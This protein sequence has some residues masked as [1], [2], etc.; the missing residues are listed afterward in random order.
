MQK[1]ITLF[2]F[3]DES[4]SPAWWAYRSNTVGIYTYHGEY[5]ALLSSLKKLNALKAL[6]PWLQPILA[7]DVFFRLQPLSPSAKAFA[8]KTETAETGLRHKNSVRES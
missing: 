1:C 4:I 2:S 7:G 8:D 5:I 3:G 6:P